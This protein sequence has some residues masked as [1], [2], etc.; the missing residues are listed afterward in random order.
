MRE[1]DRGR[2]LALQ[3]RRGRVPDDADDF[4]RA[5]IRHPI[6]RDVFS[7][8]VVIWEKLS[9]HRL[10]DDDDE[11]RVRRFMVVKIATPKQ[12]N[13]HDAKETARDCKVMCSLWCFV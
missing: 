1:V 6:Q 8:R 2:L 3:R 11:R 13:F 4:S 12:R 9:S 10:V 7:Y 5:F